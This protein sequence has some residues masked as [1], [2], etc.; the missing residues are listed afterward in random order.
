ML[1][2]HLSWLIIWGNLF[3]GLLG[4]LSEVVLIII[5]RSTHNV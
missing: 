5:V 4:L 1:R 3:G 2:K